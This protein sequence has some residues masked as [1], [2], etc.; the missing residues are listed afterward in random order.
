MQPVGLEDETYPH[1]ASAPLQVFLRAWRASAGAKLG[2]DKPISQKEVAERMQVSERWYRS[3][4]AGDPVPLSGERLG[5]LASALVLGA[6]EQ[7]ALY[8]HA[9]GGEPEPQA[10]AGEALDALTLLVEQ[11]GPLPMYLAD[12]AWNVIAYNATAAEW[13]PW[14]RAPSPN[15]LRWALTTPEAREQLVDWRHNAEMYLA[16]LRFTMLSGHDDAEV[17]R[18]LGE[19]LAVPECRR[20]WDQGTQIIAYRQ[21][22]RFG[23]RLPWVSDRNIAVTAQVLLPAYV[24][25]IRSVVLMPDAEAGPAPGAPGN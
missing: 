16:Q 3:L 7:M 14:F 18:L 15:V 11:A 17:R 8:A 4:E 19:V 10:D 6:D 9:L 25:G 13:F 2:R 1:A 22:H 12:R 21:G 20:L 23:L 5:Q 24:P